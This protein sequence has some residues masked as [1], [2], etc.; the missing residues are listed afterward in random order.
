MLVAWLGETE[1]RLHMAAESTPVESI[2]A[3]CNSLFNKIKNVKM[4]CFQLTG[5]YFG[6]YLHLLHEGEWVWR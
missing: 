5:V 2:S 3:T 6:Q 4:T 1:S